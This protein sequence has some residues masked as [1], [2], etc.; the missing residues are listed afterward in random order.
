VP[1]SQSIREV[2]NRRTDL[3]T[4][5]V[6]LTR[7]SEGRTA[8]QALDSIISGRMLRAR[9]P[10]GWA[11][12]QDD[13]KDP[14][15]QTQRV[16]CFS[17]TPLEHIYSLV[18]DIEGR[19]IRLQPYGLAFTKL[20]ARRMGINPIWYIDMTPGQDWILQRAIETLR[21]EAI[22]T[23]KF[24]EQ[25]MARLTPFLEQMG[26]W[27]TRQKEFWWER[28]WRHVGD[29]L[30]AASGIIWLCPENESDSLPAGI[31]PIIDPRWGLEQII[32]KLAGFASEDVTPF[33]PHQEPPEQDWFDDLEYPYDPD[34][35]DW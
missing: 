19:A 29:L 5:V 30:L 3:S 6:H 14:K 27:P 11:K 31:G 35:E 10:M 7:D 8:R 33:A 22:K 32:A 16:V 20:V 34:D 23:G 18:T 2:L 13:P 17:E 25:P 26:T 1:V 4:F 15:K 28:E 9:T 12:E 24:H 21:D